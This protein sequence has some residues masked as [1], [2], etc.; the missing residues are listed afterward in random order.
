MRIIDRY[1]A[2]SII[3]IFFS[4]I[5][6]FC[7]LYILIDMASNLDEILDRQVPWLILMEYYASFFPIIL[8]QTSTISCLIAVLLTYSHL[9]TNNEAIVLR[10]SGLSF[11]QIIRPAII[12]GLIVSAFIFW[13]NERYVP[14]ATTQSRSIRNENIILAVDSQR[15][16]QAKIKNLTFY[17]L[18]NR[19]FYIDSFDPD[20]FEMEGITIIGQ[21]NNQNLKEKINALKGKWTGI[22]WKFYQCSISYFDSTNLASP[23]QYNYYEEKLLDIK[24]TP[25]DFLRQRINVTSMNIRQLHEYINRFSDSGAVKAINNL[26]VDLHEKIA[27]PFGNLVVILVG[28][29]LALMSGRRKAMTFTNMNDF[30]T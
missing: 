30:R 12:F 11:W 20:T 14:M 3:S 2:R 8:V 23:E 15:K 27:Y 10:S 28:L 26:R 1:I 21:Y 25:Q 29:P 16:K 18:K 24:E 13:L 7:F 9:N 22:A 4:T 17:G 6:V 5:F 19:L